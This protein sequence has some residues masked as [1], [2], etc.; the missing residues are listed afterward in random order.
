MS[1]KAANA[2]K[3]KVK[4]IVFLFTVFFLSTVV[5][6]GQP[7]FD[8]EEM[9]KMQVQQLTEACVL[10]EGQVTKVEAIVRETSRKMIETFQ[11]GQGGD[12][13]ELREKM[14]LIQEEYNKKIKEI[15]NKEQVER[16]EKYLIEQSERMRQRGGGFDE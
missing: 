2:K 10:S 16:Y 8:P 3:G 14:K 15:L 4:V 12:F 6:K 9:I 13:A 11:S 1:V 7:Q 5:V